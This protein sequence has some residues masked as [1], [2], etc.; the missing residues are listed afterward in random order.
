MKR[1]IGFTAA[2]LLWIFLLAGCSHRSA[3]IPAPGTELRTE[4][5]MVQEAVYTFP[6]GV[7]ADL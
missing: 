7:T 3:D 2:V 4:L 5:T 1:S 6:D